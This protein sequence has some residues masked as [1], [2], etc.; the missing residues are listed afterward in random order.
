MTKTIDEIII[1]G[2]LS[3][4]SPEQKVEHYLQV[5]EALGLNHKLH[6]LEYMM[7]DNQ[8]GGRSLVLYVLRNGT[9]QLRKL[10]GI[11]ITKLTKE[12]T[13]DIAIFTAEATDKDGQTDISTGAV[14]LSG[15]SG[16]ERAN[17][18]MA[19][20]TK[21]KRRVTLSISGV[22]L[23]D[24]T[25]VAD[26]NTA[27]TVVT[28]G[29]G[30]SAAPPQVSTP[31]VNSNAGMECSPSA[32]NPLGVG[33]SVQNPLGGEPGAVSLRD[34]RI[35]VY[36]NEVLQSGGIQSKAGMSIGAKWVKFVT[37]YTNRKTTRDLDSF[38]WT[39]LLDKLDEVRA[40]LGDKGVVLF[41]EETISKEIQS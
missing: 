37:T 38:D 39:K 18:I 31:A 8:N 25:E 14:S 4:L 32:A 20:E 22:G 10:H 34:P 17:A 1:T 16:Q 15:R 27:M 23:L 11:K 40:K 12:I 35:D 28:P 3:E 29:I 6:P 2:D 7:A 26:M 30:V 9:D 24:E 33:P 41:I 5:C 19:A 36:K 13:N 21:A